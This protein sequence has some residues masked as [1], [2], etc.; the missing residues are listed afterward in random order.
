MQAEQLLVQKIASRPSTEEL[1]FFIA[2]DDAINSACS[3]LQKKIA[4]NNKK[5]LKE[6][7]ALCQRYH[8]SLVHLTRELNHIQNIFAPRETVS[9]DHKILGLHAGANITEVKQSYRK[10]SIK[11]HPDTSDKNDTAK[12]IEITKAYQRIINSADKKENSATSSP[13]AWR[14]R[15]N[16]PPPRQQRKKKY[17]YFFSLITGAVVLIIVG[18]SIHYQKRAM[19]KNI[20]KISHTSSPAKPQ[21]EKAPVAIK[22]QSTGIHVPESSKTDVQPQVIEQKKLTLPTRKISEQSSQQIFQ[23]EVAFV[24]RMPKSISHVEPPAPDMQIEAEIEN[25]NTSISS[26]DG[27]FDSEKSSTQ[28]S[29]L[30]DTKS[31]IRAEEHNDFFSAILEQEKTAEEKIKAIVPAAVQ[32]I[33]KQKETG[34]VFSEAHYHKAIV[35]KSKKKKIRKEKLPAANAE[36]TTPGI[37][38]QQ[39]LRKFVQSYTAAYMSRDIQKFALFFTAEAQENGKPFSKI[40]QKYK[41]L[42]NATQSIDYSIDLLDTDIQGEKGASLTGRFKV[43]LIYS[44]NKIKSSTGTITFFLVKVK[45]NYRIKALTYHLDPK[46]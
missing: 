22:D 9:D 4:G 13:S 41:Q 17:L 33:S 45:K 43:Q 10:L 16:T 15:K 7:H 2:E 23:D 28:K 12:F 26:S 29:D 37:S 44:P 39:S 19:L 24:P 6:I 20:S 46:W 35:V 32:Q 40:R 21:A 3:E 8:I 34:S 18:I 11:Y 14:Y 31:I 30:M 38:T 25:V 36:Q 1:I 27:R 42:F 5:E